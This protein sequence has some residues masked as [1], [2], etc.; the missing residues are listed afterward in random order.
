MISA[1][2]AAAASADSDNA[3][4]DCCVQGLFIWIWRELLQS[5][6]IMTGYVHLLFLVDDIFYLY[7]VIF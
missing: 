7:L 1:A 5:C 2:A 3:Y 4:S 6:R